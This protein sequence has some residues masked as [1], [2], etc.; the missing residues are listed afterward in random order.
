MRGRVGRGGA[1]LGVT[2]EVLPS[3]G[4]RHSVMEATAW[5]SDPALEWIYSDKTEGEKNLRDVDS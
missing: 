5:L 1:G 4:S 2:F 3:F